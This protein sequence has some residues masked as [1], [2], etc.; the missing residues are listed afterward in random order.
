[1][2]GT[3]KTIIIFCILLVQMLSRFLEFEI[4]NHPGIKLS[5]IFVWRWK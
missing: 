3:G 1:M 2:V 5:S 4:R